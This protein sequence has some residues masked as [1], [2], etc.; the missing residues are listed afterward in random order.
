MRFPMS[1]I[2]L[3]SGGTIASLQGPNDRPSGA[4]GWLPQNVQNDVKQVRLD[5]GTQAS[6]RVGHC[7]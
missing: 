5:P 3:H 4:Q 2:G 7:E 6:Q 1:T